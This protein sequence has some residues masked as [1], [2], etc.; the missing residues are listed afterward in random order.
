M[1]L[2]TIIEGT[3]ELDH[4]LLLVERRRQALSPGGDGG[5]A[6]AIEIME[7]IINPILCDLEVFLKGR[8]T[9]SMTLP[10]VRDLVSGWI[11]EQI[12]RENG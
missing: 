1:N 5:E 2:E 11:D 6:E 7:R 3:G 10:E 4:L 8:V 12:A 9:A